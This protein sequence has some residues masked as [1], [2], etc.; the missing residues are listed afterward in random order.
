VIDAT[1]IHNLHDL[2]GRITTTLGPAQHQGMQD[3]IDFFIMK[4]PNSEFNDLD[5]DADDDED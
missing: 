3:I 5:L 2:R 4:Y 1:T